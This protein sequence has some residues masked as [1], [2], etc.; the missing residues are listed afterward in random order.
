MKKSKKIKFLGGFDIN[1][2]SPNIFK[3]KDGEISLKEYQQMDIKQKELYIKK[4]LKLST[5][6]LSTTQKYILDFY[7]PKSAENTVNYKFISMDDIDSSIKQIENDTDSVKVVEEVFVEKE[8]ELTMNN[9]DQNSIEDVKIYLDSFFKIE[10]P[11]WTQYF[12]IYNPLQKFIDATSN[13][14]I[15]DER[16]IKYLELYYT[17]KRKQI[18]L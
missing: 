3:Y 17:L 18:R 2:G 8:Q 5:D 9:I 15:L 16:T 7:G 10:Y 6:N 1:S 12:S 4:L 14:M 11:D 13:F